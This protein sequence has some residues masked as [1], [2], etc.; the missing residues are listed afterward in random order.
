MTS[1]GTLLDAGEDYIQ[2]IHTEITTE[3]LLQLE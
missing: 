1:G 2:F 3:N